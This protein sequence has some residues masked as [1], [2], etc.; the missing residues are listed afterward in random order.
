MGKD[1][2]ASGVQPLVA[3]GV[4][5]VPMRVDEVLDRIGTNRGQRVSNFWTRTGKAGI[6]QQLTVP[7]GENRDISTGPHQNVYV[8]AEFLDRDGA[9]GGRSACCLYKPVILSEEL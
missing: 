1:G 9:G 8:A 7:T 5:K 2:C 3:I 4:I 6:G